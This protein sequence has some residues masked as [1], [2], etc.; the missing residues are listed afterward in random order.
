MRRFILLAAS[1]ITLSSTML[2]TPSSEAI[3]FPHAADAVH[4]HLDSLR[5]SLWHRHRSH[6]CRGAWGDWR[7]RGCRFVRPRYHAH[8]RWH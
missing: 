3:A 1:A 4:N 8:W 5:H 6:K 7:G 2:I